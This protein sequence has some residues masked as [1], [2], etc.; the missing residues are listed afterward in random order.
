[1]ACFDSHLRV[2][3]YMAEAAKRK[4]S[5]SAVNTELVG[6]AETPAIM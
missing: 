1:M 3:I 5:A 2:S 4:G 6:L